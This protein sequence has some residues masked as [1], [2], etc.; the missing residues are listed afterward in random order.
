MTIGDCIEFGLDVASRFSAYFRYL[1]DSTVWSLKCLFAA[2]PLLLLE[3]LVHFAC[4]CDLSTSSS[5]S[6]KLVEPGR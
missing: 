5:T 3:L 4:I 6:R 1:P 2:L